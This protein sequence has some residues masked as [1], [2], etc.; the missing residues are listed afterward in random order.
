M[1]TDYLAQ[2]TGGNGAANRVDSTLYAVTRDGFKYQVD[3]RGLDPNGFILYGNTVG[4]L[5]PDGVTPLYHD[6]VADI[7]PLTAIQGGVMLSPP[8]GLLFV[9]PPAADLPSSIMPTPVVPTVNSIT[10]QGTAGDVD[11]QPGSVFSTGGNIVFDGNIGGVAHVVI[12]PNPGGS[13]GC[14]GADFN[15]SLPANRSLVRVVAAGVQNLAWDGRDN[16]GAYMP[17][18]WTGNGG[19]G[20]CFSATLHAGEYHFPLLDAENSVLGGPTITLLNPPGGGCPFATCSTAFFDDRG[21]RTDERR[22]GRQRRLRPVRQQPTPAAGLQRR[23][24]RHRIDRHPGLRR[25]LQ[26]WLRQPEGPG[27]V[28]LLP[29]PG[30]GRAA[31]R[32][33]AVDERP[34]DHQDAHGQLRGRRPGH[35]HAHASRTWARRR[36]TAWSR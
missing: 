28:D 19:S 18:S 13:V 15:S 16:S 32:R 6:L 2:I 21:Y 23:R 5:N 17:A 33:P 8:T 1:F 26:H 24:L 11:G 4:F 12:A 14:A 10:F 25:Q 27:P 22:H 3:L 35:L 34:R 36:S 31:L 7:N 20:Y 29:E 30:R 9:A